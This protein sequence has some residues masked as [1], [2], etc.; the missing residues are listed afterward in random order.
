MN[1]E[2]TEKKSS[3]AE[4]EK[5]G[6]NRRVGRKAG[7]PAFDMER[8]AVYR[9]A[10]EGVSLAQT[11]ETIIADVEKRFPWRV[12]V[13]LFNEMQQS[14]TLKVAPGMS[15]SYCSAPR[16][17]LGN[18]GCARHALQTSATPLFLENIAEAAE[19][20]HCPQRIKM[21]ALQR[22]AG[23]SALWSAPLANTQGESLGVMNFYARMPTQPNAEMQASFQRFALEAGRAVAFWE[24]EQQLRRALTVLSIAN[25]G[26]I[27]TDVDARIVFVNKAW[28]ERSGYS[29]EEAIGQRPSLVKSNLQGQAFYQEMWSILR[30]NDEWQGEIVNRNKSGEALPQFLR[31]RGVR[32]KG[33]LTHYVG[34]ITD[35]TRLK[36]SEREAEQLAHY[37]SLT[38]LP[39]RLLAISRL[40]FALE[41]A[42]RN[43]SRLGVICINLDR[44]KNINNSLGYPTGDQVLQRI[45][46]RIKER[47]RGKDT[48]ARLGGDEF[49]LIQEHV[50]HP[51]EVAR[52]AQ[53]M[54]ELMRQPIRLE[55]ENEVYTSA[56][57]GVSVY[58]EDGKTASELIQHADTAMYHA[59]KQGRDT[60]CFYTAELSLQMRQRMHLE[61]QMRRAL[62]NGEFKL[63]YQPQAD[64]VNGK[65][66]GVESLM[67]WKSPEFG[68]I[69]PGE[70]IPVAEQSGLI[71]N[72]GAWA[73]N[74]ACAQA[75]RW[76]DEGLP[77]LVMAVNVS[78]YQFR[79]KNL[80][81]VVEEAL[82]QSGLPAHYL[83]IELTESAF[84]EDAEEAITITH[85]LHDLGVKLALDDFG[86]GYSSLAYLSRFT[87]D[88]IKI[89][90]G[91]VRDITSNT[92]NAAIASATIALAKSLNISSLAEGVENE[93]QLD[94]L[95]QRGCASVQGFLFSHPLDAEAC[96]TFLREGKHLP[97]IPTL[98]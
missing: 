53:L 13:W 70:F 95:R 31:V 41:E 45:A 65:I 25:D 39:N 43:G 54:L 52:M 8:R 98:I 47:V 68:S 10:F 93:H 91:F 2:R 5:T 94:F 76:L 4:Q 35:L 48:L 11:L 86:T 32:D 23:F 18:Y 38:R 63:F 9:L 62:E 74:E 82:K 87:L 55:A 79:S 16:G 80:L 81:S 85:K 17:A 71:F 30:E 64:I 6:G 56:S 33:V 46:R 1:S 3:I 40:N 7:E 72:L 28:C 89:D 59:K 90:Q 69:A 49:M 21:Q 12:A 19:C 24:Q 83:E 37:D 97:V 61:T 66:N 22:G 60:F 36:Q 77:P 29:Q 75:R 88:K 96:T 67:R 57:L 14:F 20:A 78:V 42:E 50:R 92:T 84:F 15:K 73:M 44:F 34:V 58:P 26:V 51:D 27:V